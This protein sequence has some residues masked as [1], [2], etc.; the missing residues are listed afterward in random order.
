MC[1]YVWSKFDF[2][3]FPKGA[4]KKHLMWALMFLMIYGK[5]SVMC[6][7]AD[8]VDENTL[9]KWTAYFVDE[10]ALLQ[11]DIVSSPLHAS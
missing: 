7:L 1:E 4:N 10:I 3:C 5:E 11:N 2:T 6:S 8:G 9:R